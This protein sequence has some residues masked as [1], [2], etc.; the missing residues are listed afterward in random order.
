MPPRKSKPMSDPRKGRF[1]ITKAFSFSAAHSLPTLPPDHKCHRL[2]GHNYIVEVCVGAEKLDAAGMVLDFAT[3]SEVVK[4]LVDGIDHRNLNDFM[5]FP[6]TSENLAQYFY[7]ACEYK[8]D[9]ARV[10]WVSV[11]ETP[12]SK[13]I[14]T[15]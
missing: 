15:R 3:I 10:D 14:Y 1:Q 13:A 4:P 6:T 12:T 5:S 7:L 2:H 9:G 8:F 11:S